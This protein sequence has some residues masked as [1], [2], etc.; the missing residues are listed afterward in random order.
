MAETSTDRPLV[1][2]PDNG[3]ARRV[4]DRI[5][6]AREAAGISQLE[7]GSRLGR[8]QSAISYWESG[9]R[10]I[11]A[12]ELLVVAAVLAVP[13]A[14]LLPIGSR[15]AGP[16]RLPLRVGRKAPNQTIYDADD[17]MVAAGMTP[18]SAAWIVA[19]ANQAVNQHG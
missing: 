15:R 16:Y 18:E 19:V 1:V 10:Q 5:R 2:I 14:V 4:G 3:I 17:V 9:A 12:S 8:A 6:A 13:P 11:N 7:L